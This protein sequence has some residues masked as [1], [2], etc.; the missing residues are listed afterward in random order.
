MKALVLSGGSIKGAYQAGAIST[1]LK[2]GFKPTLIYGVSVGSLNGAFIADRAGA[3][4]ISGNS[5]PDWE[6]IGQELTTFWTANIRSFKDIGKKRGSFGIFWKILRKKFT[7]LLK[8]GPL[9]DLMRR[10]LSAERIK[11]APAIFHAGVVDLESGEFFN[12]THGSA[13]NKLVDFVI[14][15]TREPIKMPIHWIKTKPPKGGAEKELP[16]VDGGARNIAPLGEAIGKGATEIV[17]IA[18]QPEDIKPAADGLNYRDFFKIAS[19][20]LAIMTNEIVNNDLKV[21]EATNRYCLQHGDPKKDFLVG[22]DDAHHAGHKFVPIR[23]IRPKEPIKVSI[24]EFTTADIALMIKQ[25]RD[26]V[27]DEW[28]ATTQKNIDLLADATANAN[29]CVNTGA[30]GGGGNGG[31][32]ADPPADIAAGQPPH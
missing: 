7:G 32:S 4:V 23:I 1:V 27:E 15:S 3:Q 19:R 14:A 24:T 2:K 18:C 9:T 22:D 28:D 29:T 13:G 21:A 16:L 25:G 6:G 17:V 30:N 12:A 8:M 5:N 31:D 10:S 26:Q 20:T 11:K